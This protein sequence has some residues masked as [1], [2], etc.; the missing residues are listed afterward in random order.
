MIFQNCRIIQGLATTSRRHLG[1]PTSIPTDD[2]QHKCER[3]IGDFV[4]ALVGDVEDRNIRFTHYFQRRFG[5][6][7]CDCTCT[8]DILRTYGKDLG[9]IHDG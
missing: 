7:Y 9:S 3:M 1:R 8:K 5:S 4:D 6:S 2:A